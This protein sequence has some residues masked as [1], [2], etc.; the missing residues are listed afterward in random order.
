MSKKV[1]VLFTALCLIFSTIE[2]TAPV[3]ASGQQTG[4]ITYY[5]SLQGSD[6][7][8]GTLAQ[9]FRTIEKARDTVRSLKN[10]GGLTSPVTVYIREGTYYLDQTITFTQDDSGT[11]SCPV[12]YAA[13]PG[14][15]PVISG[16]KPISGTWRQETTGS[17]IYCVDLPEAAAGAWKFRSLFGD[18]QREIR[19]R[20]PNYVPDYDYYGTSYLYNYQNANQIMSGIAITGDYLEY[21]FDVQTAGTYKLWLGYTSANTNNQNYLA[22]KIDG[23]EV[24][25]GNMPSTGGWRN[26]GYYPMSDVNLTQGTHT[27]RIESTAYLQ[28]NRVH[29]DGFVF[30]DNPNFSS[31]L[32]AYGAL[33]SLASGEKRIVVQ[34]EDDTCRISGY[35][36]I[37]FQKFVVGVTSTGTKI[38]IDPKEIKASWSPSVEPDALI[39]M[40]TNLNYFDEVL[41]ITSIDQATGVINVSGETQSSLEPGN[42]F[43][44]SG[45]KEELDSPGEWYLDSVQGKLYYWPREGEDPNTMDFVA[46]KLD[47]IINLQGNDIGTE[48]ARWITFSGLSFKHCADT[49]NHIADRTPT[50]GAVKL[51][52][53]YNITIENCLF[54]NIDGFGVW[55]HL[56]SCDNTI[57]GNTMEYMGTGG[58]LMTSAKIAY[59]DSYSVIDSRP[60]VQNYAPMRNII[61]RN[62]IHHGNEVRVNG[63]GILLDSRPDSTALMPG[64]IMLYNEIH[65]MKRQGIFGFKN[66]A[67]NIVA[68]NN[69]YQT[70]LETADGGAINFAAM[71]NTV[72]PSY[73][74]NNVVHDTVGLKRQKKN[75]YNTFI[76]AGIYLD[77]GSSN[78]RIEN[79][80]VYNS[81]RGSVLNHGGQL[82][83][84]INNIFADSTGENFYIPENS[85]DYVKGVMLYNNVIANTRQQGS[86]ISLTP[87][88]LPA[89]RQP[90]YIA[91]VN[92]N[93]KQMIHSNKNILW[94]VGFPIT[95][96]PVTGD[97]TQWKNL[98][99]D[100]DS[101]TTDPLFVD[102]EHGNYNLKAESPAYTLGFRPIDA[103][104]VG[105][106]ATAPNEPDFT[107]VTVQTASVTLQNAVNQGE[108]GKKFVPSIPAAGNYLVYARLS[109]STST[110]PQ[111]FFEV[112]HADGT[113]NSTLSDCATPLSYPSTNMQYMG[114]Y[115][116][117]AGTGNSSV[118]FEPKD[119]LS[120]S[121][122]P[123]ELLLVKTNLVDAN[124]KYIRDL[125]LTSD[126]SKMNVGETAALSVKAVY[127]DNSI[128]DLSGAQISYVVSDPSKGT[129]DQNGRLTV[130]K[131]GILS[132]TAQISVDGVIVKSLP[133]YIKVGT[134]LREVQLTVP[135][136]LL[137]PGD[138]VNAVVSGKMTDGSAADISN[139]QLSFASSNPSIVTVDT[140]G[141]ITAV[142]VGTAKITV[143]ATLNGITVSS[144]AVD[145]TVGDY[146]LLMQYKFDEVTSGNTAATDYGTVSPAPGNFSGSATRTTNTPGGFSAAALDLTANSSNNNYVTPGTA[147]SSKIDNLNEMTVSF[148]VY[149][150]GNPA[151][152]DRIVS[153]GYAFDWQVTNSTSTPSAVT[154]VIKIGTSASDQTTITLPVLNLSKW[155]FVAF[156]Y[157]RQQLKLYVGDAE[158]SA[159]LVGTYTC[160]KSATDPT[161]EF[162]IG[163]TVLS[164]AD[165]T[166]PAY[167]DDIRVYNLALPQSELDY[168]RKENVI[169]MVAPKWTNASINVS[170]VTASSVK[171]SWNGASDNLA[172]AGYKLYKNGLELATV[173]SNTYDVT[174]LEEYTNYNLKVEALD[175]A[176]NLSV[177]G[178]SVSITT[179]DVTPP[180]SVVLVNGSEL[181]DG[182]VFLDCEPLLIEIKGKDDSSGIQTVSMDV[183]GYNYVPGT[184]LDLAGQIGE[185]Y[186]RTAVIDNAGNKAE[187]LVTFNVITSLTSMNTIIERYEAS[188]ALKAP[189]LPLLRN[190][191]RQAG[192]ML[193]AVEK[194]PLLSRL[195]EFMNK[196]LE[197][198]PNITD[199]LK[200][201]IEKVKDKE[202]ILR[203]EQAAKHME[204][205]VK[206]LTDKTMQQYVSADAKVSLVNDAN[207]I[208]EEWSVR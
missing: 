48:R 136:Q 109:G 200:K 82:N 5:V 76:G 3:F 114:T 194:N 160:T 139:L 97:Y 102:A 165:R 89:A 52:S 193:D 183:Y 45:V 16:G 25:L 85:T 106:N 37:G 21:G 17:S 11:Q 10:A 157:N 2:F 145:I 69:I 147:G 167:F 59:A 56:D 71:N 33:P 129:V 207:S 41:K 94:N 47:R 156:T 57:S 127:S 180:T 6:S 104:N 185:K 24:T 79:N 128:T 70:M 175:G 134:Y 163:S 107:W 119:S 115:R 135:K 208:I 198:R 46:P 137:R 196:S 176:G 23:Q 166:P 26:P 161:K 159:V 120:T 150:R 203:Y 13:Y 188:G 148:W 68:Y 12:T 206:H 130:S 178:P 179:L 62:L 61:K 189:L 54:T 98:G 154:S 84:Y 105:L 1:L 53:A 204:D 19:A 170:D 86:I 197:D 28:E 124:Y 113:T 15:K 7:W 92:L 118:T 187:A 64:N 149:M 9:P 132:V 36:S 140:A 58:I 112:S 40:V 27:I 4:Q 191:L 184:Q 18:G 38:Q 77:H 31:P 144:N 162:R 177:G 42:Y 146:K 66:Q 190:D 141:T 49:I 205:F 123:M 169:D 78:Y 65:H 88:V 30:T 151:L 51:T 39:D 34:A 143:A 95:I 22:V 202:D 44:I 29:M 74:M 103:N 142:A 90:D 126:K 75:E 55:L 133:A 73:I 35:T 155:K 186:V 174:G 50:D 195:E 80:I 192:H 182:A 8:P 158:S 152:Y 153:K 91:Q 20:Y 122:Y 96:P 164:T 138:T 168:I 43:Y 121:D 111:V 125:N 87:G 32:G 199:L 72:A 201:K 99:E 108:L 100:S 63:A 93:P 14:E 173:S 172:L 117:N 131:E 67:G 81:T 110:V 181:K 101:I 171:L 116:F 60:E 83:S